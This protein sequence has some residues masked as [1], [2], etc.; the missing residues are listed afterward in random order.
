MTNLGDIDIKFTGDASNFAKAIDRAIAAVDKSIAKNEEASRAVAAFGAKSSTAV[1]A[2]ANR[3]IA[4]AQRAI[5][6]AEN[7]TRRYRALNAANISDIQ[8]TALREEAVLERLANRREAAADKAV[9]AAAR[10]AKSNRQED[11]VGGL[12]SRETIAVGAGVLSAGIAAAGAAAVSAASDLEQVNGLLR[13]I[14]KD[15]GSDAAVFA[16]DLNKQFGTS[17]VDAQKG[18]ANLGAQLSSFLD[19]DAALKQSK[20]IVRLAVDLSSAYNK[21]LPETIERIQSGLRGETEA[22]EKLNIFVGAAQIEQEALR[23]GYKKS[24]QEMNEAEKQQFRLAILFRDGAKAAGAAAQE[25][26]TFES[27]SRQL[28]ASVSNLAASFGKLLLPAATSFVD[29]A[30]DVVN[31]VNQI[32]TP[33]KAVGV[34]AA[35]LTAALSALVAGIAT[36]NALALLH[37]P[38]TLATMTTSF[39]SAATNGVASLSS[40]L[41]SLIG[42]Q[43]TQYMSNL[44]IGVGAVGAAFITATVAAGTLVLAFES[45]G[46]VLRALGVDARGLGESIGILNEAFYD[47]RTG[48]QTWSDLFKD[49]AVSVT[50]ALSQFSVL[51]QVMR[52]VGLID[53]GTFEKLRAA[54]GRAGDDATDTTKKF[55]DLKKAKEDALATG[56]SQAVENGQSNAFGDGGNSSF[57]ATLATSSKEIVKAEDSAKR[58]KKSANDVLK[59]IK[60]AADARARAI[61]AAFKENEK[62]VKQD[63]E[64]QARLEK[65][66]QDRRSNEIKEILKSNA[67]KVALEKELA[68]KISAIR[69][70]ASDESKSNKFSAIGADGLGSLLSSF[71]QKSAEIADLQKRGADDTI[72]A[73]LEANSLFIQQFAAELAKIPEY[74][75]P[76]AIADAAASSPGNAGLIAAAQAA[77]APKSN[78]A[79]K[80]KR[81]GD[82]K[83]AEDAIDEI[84]RSLNGAAGSI[85]RFVDDIQNASGGGFDF[86]FEPL[87]KSIIKYS[88]QINLAAQV[89]TSVASLISS[90]AQILA[91]AAVAVVDQ[92]SSFVSSVF[93]SSDISNLFSDIV[94]SAAKS[95][96]RSGFLSAFKSLASTVSKVI[97]PIFAE[98]GKVLIPVVGVLSSAFKLLAPI[99]ERIASIAIGLVQDLLPA[100]SSI[101]KVIIDVLDGLSPLFDSLASGIFK[102]FD[103]L[104]VVFQR[105]KEPLIQLGEVLSSVTDI[106]INAFDFDALS[107]FVSSFVTMLSN[108]TTAL[109]P[110]FVGAVK[111]L[112]GILEALGG[113]FDFIGALF[114]LLEPLFVVIGYI[115]EGVGIVLGAIGKAFTFIANLIIDF[116]NLFRDENNKIKRFKFKEEQAPRT[117]DIIPSDLGV[118]ANSAA[119][120][121][122]NLS[123]EIR[124]ATSDFKIAR[125]RYGASSQ[126]GGTGGA[127]FPGLTQ[128]ITGPIT[129]ISNNPL[130]MFQEMQRIQ[131]RNNAAR[132]GGILGRAAWVGRGDS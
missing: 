96:D 84:G 13:L 98:I 41:L 94:S 40:S 20:A 9:A 109:A 25:I 114:V 91:S 113:I 33:M 48:G 17:L 61:A 92:I 71:E 43:T 45:T 1:D 103:G 62:L 37:V 38:R 124:N 115:L 97:N 46:S 76:Q 89:V 14:F 105:V 67:E 111:V 121:L 4:A 70:Q 27:R 12:R 66:D 22:I 49:L 131:Q 15:R 90:G 56:T 128:S 51:G 24:I 125:Y 3:Q 18:I 26:D 127:L 16:D 11:N 79:D 77:S 47:A 19:P 116:A 83:A 54:L 58:A 36:F 126:E 120:G 132:T 100:F 7:A 73:Q 53:E 64:T 42:I 68:D 78:E 31:A 101:I 80:A 52:Y 29:I 104:V 112:N 35:G 60:E 85:Y 81:A 39:V 10:I 72:N 44:A 74:L 50:Q 5:A 123:D 107:K 28:N 95:L 87:E 75:R 129:V 86:I 93:A 130:Q 2:A 117:N 32:P 69:K 23:Q 88:D 63:D 30:K 118:N 99:I 108:I 110:V 8:K 119:D 122:G 82:A 6:S 57:D 59:S 21:S 106:I 34:A 55:E 65:E 102:I